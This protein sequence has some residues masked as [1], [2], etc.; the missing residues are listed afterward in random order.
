MNFKKQ[1]AGRQSLA[2]IY[3]LQGPPHSPGLSSFLRASLLTNWF[4]W[5]FG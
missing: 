5:L 3:S 4:L 2:S 1:K